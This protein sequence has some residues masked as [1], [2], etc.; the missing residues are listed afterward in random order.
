MKATKDNKIFF[1]KNQVSFLKE[2]FL[3]NNIDLFND[4]NEA[5]ELYCYYTLELDK[6]VDGESNFIA[7][8]KAKVNNTLQAVKSG[9]VSI[10]ILS[11][12]FEKKNS[13]WN[14][15]DN[16]QELYYQNTLTEKHQNIQKP[17]FTVKDFEIYAE[18]KHCLAYIPIL[19]LD[20]LFNGYH[21]K[22]TLKKIYKHIFFAIQMNDDLE[23][24]TKDINNNQ[25]TYLHAN[26]D[27]FIEQEKIKNNTDLTNFKERVL[28]VSG[29]GSEAITYSKKH[30]NK[31]LELS[32]ELK[33]TELTSWLKKTISDIESNEKLILSLLD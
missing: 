22:M 14:D 21:D 3:I 18:A 10:Q 33:L 4:F 30:F 25:W 31:A 9:Q 17:N 26:V 27:N 16:M 19:G 24:Y 20:Y 5:V 2:A 1:F 23:D 11:K 32:L 13:F 28:Y 15:L 12:I 6:I 29:I 7:Q 8:H